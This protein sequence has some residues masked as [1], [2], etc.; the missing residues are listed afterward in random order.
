MLQIPCHLQRRTVNIRLFDLDAFDFDLRGQ[1]H[2]FHL[3]YQTGQC[4]ML[5]M[6]P[7]V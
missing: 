3:V 4:N 2:Q 1:V 7:P 6:F 5:H